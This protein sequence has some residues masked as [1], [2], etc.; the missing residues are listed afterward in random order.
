MRS[1]P[2]R[3][4]LSVVVTEHDPATGATT[5]T[6]WRIDLR[7][8]PREMAGPLRQAVTFAIPI[9][10][11]TAQDLPAMQA[12]LAR[13]LDE[14]IDGYPSSSSHVGGYSG[15]VSDSTASA[16][17]Q[18]MADQRT[19]LTWAVNHQLDQTIVAARALRGALERLARA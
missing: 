15:D 1:H 6:S 2:L 8:A 14:D 5:S 18:R 3:N 7:A 12:K 16:A 19:D 11:A 17:E 9:I 4:V 13:S 10:A